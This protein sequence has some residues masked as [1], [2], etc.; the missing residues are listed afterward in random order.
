MDKII[1]L[2]VFR[3]LNNTTA[4]KNVSDKQLFRLPK[5]FRE[6]GNMVIKVLGTREQ[7]VNKAGNTGVKL[8]R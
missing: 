6:K 2:D 4:R 8:T 1:S 7:K 5:S 3:L